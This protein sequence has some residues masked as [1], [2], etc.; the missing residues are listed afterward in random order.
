MKKWIWF[1]ADLQETIMRTH[2]QSFKN[3]FSDIADSEILLEDFIR[4]YADDKLDKPLKIGSAR[5]G[6]WF[7]INNISI[8]HKMVVHHCLRI[9]KDF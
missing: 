1:T 6:V 8:F 4:R 3:H 9:E 2:R 7:Y 5:I